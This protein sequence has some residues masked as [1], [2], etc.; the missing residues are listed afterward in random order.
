MAMSG[1]DVLVSGHPQLVRDTRCFLDVNGIRA[2]APP[3]E[4]PAYCIPFALPVTTP[5]MIIDLVKETYLTI[6]TILLTA[7]VTRWITLPRL[8]ISIRDQSGAVL[9]FE[10]TGRQVKAEIESTL[11]YVQCPNCRLFVPKGNFCDICGR[12]S[13]Y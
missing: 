12:T 6:L 7:V 11:G 10:G 5:E 9:K 3:V 8:S 1:P 13:S 4:G 2:E